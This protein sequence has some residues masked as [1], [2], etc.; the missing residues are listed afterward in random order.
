M[1]GYFMN[2]PRVTEYQFVASVIYKRHMGG[3]TSV[4]NIKNM[5]FLLSYHLNNHKIALGKILLI[6][7]ESLESQEFWF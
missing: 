7:M 6:V 3:Y 4:L 1:F 5:W 2:K